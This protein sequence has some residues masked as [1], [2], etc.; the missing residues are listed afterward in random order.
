LKYYI[1][2]YAKYSLHR[3]V[4]DRDMTN[5]KQSA[6]NVDGGGGDVTSEVPNKGERP[7][8]WG[9]ITTLP[10]LGFFC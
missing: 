4:C 1:E 5:A 8:Q 3:A 9:L 6:Y 10:F 7:Q 2:S